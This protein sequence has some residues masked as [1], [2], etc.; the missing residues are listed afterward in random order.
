MTTDDPSATKTPNPYLLA[1][2]LTGLGVITAILLD[3]EGAR[4]LAPLVGA[5]AISCWIGGARPGLLSCA[6]GFGVVW[7]GLIDRGD[8]LGMPGTSELARWLTPL[9]VSLVVVWASWALRRVGAEATS[10]AETAVRE[11]TTTESVQRLTSELSSALTPSDVAHA[12]VERVPVLLGATGGAF[13]LL[14]GDQALQIVDPDGAPQQTLRPGLRLP[15]DTRAP[16]VQAARS[17]EVAFAATRALLEQEFPDGARLA[18]NAAGALAVPLRV[19]GVV[20]GSMG[21][22]FAEPDA[23]DDEVVTLATLAADLGGQALQRSRLYEQERDSRAALDRI[24][25]L[26][27]R[28]GSE[29]PQ[30]VARLVCVE[31]AETFGADVAQVWVI[32]DE[33]FE[34][35]WR[36]PESEVIPPG[37]RIAA[38]DFPGLAES[39]ERLEAMFIEDSLVNIKGLGLQHA[40]HF[41]IRS[42]LRIPIASGGRAE[43]ILVLQWTSVVPRPPVS[44][45]ALTRR[46][47]DL[48]GLALEH[49]ERRVAQADAARNSDETRRLL[50]LTAALSAALQPRAVAEATL[51]EAVR[52]FGATGGVVVR[53]RDD[54][55]LDVEAVLGPVADEVGDRRRLDDGT[56]ITRAARSNDLIVVDETQVAFPLVAVGRIVGSLELVFDE[57]RPF[58]APDRE[59]ALAL[60]RQSGQA[61]ERTALYETE[62]DARM[63][64]ERMA[65]DLAQLHALATALGRTGAAEEVTHIIGEQMTAGMIGAHT[66]GVYLLDGSRE[67][68]RLASVTGKLG[69]DYLAEFTDLDIERAAPITEAVR[70][71]KPVWLFGDE[72]DDEVR[73]ARWREAG[74]GSVGIIPLVVES[75]AI[76]ALFVMFDEGE[77]PTAEDRRFA[78]TVARQSAQPLERVRLLDE[79]RGS[80]RRAERAIEELR[81]LQAVTESL[82]GAP[83]TAAV[84]DVMLR[85]GRAVLGADGALVHLRT[86][87][88]EDLVLLDAL[89]APTALIAP[90]A[91]L[92]PDVGAAVNAAYTSG[93]VIELMPVG[94]GSGS[95]GLRTAFRTILCIPLTVGGDTVGVLTAGF[96]QARTFDAEDRRTASVM[97]RQC[98]QAL[99]RSRLFDEERDARDRSERLQSLTTALSRALTP[100]DVITTY[101]R[102]VGPAVGARSVAVGIVEREG[103]PP[104]R[105]Q[106][107]GDVADV[108]THWLETRPEV[109][110]P[111][112]AALRDDRPRYHDASPPN[113]T[114]GGADTRDLRARALIPLLVRRR[115][116]GVAVL[117]WDRSLALDDQDRSFLEAC[118]SLCAQALDRAR[119]YDAERTIAETLQRSVLPETLP[120]MEG[121]TVAARYLPGTE[122]V[123]VG[124]DWFDTILLPDGRLG[125]AVGDVVGKGVEAA[126]TMAQLRNGMRALALDTS[127]PGKIVTKLNKLLDGYSESS[128]ATL[129]FVAVDPTTRVATIVCA[130]HPPPVVVGSDGV[131]SLLDHG[132]GL[133]LGVDTEATYD[134][135]TTTLEAGAILVLYTDGLVERRDRSFDDGLALLCEAVS[136][137]L[138]EPEE[139]I[140][141]ILD[142]LLGDSERGDDIAV[143]TVALDR[144]PLGAFEA[145]LPADRGSLRGLREAFEGWLDR[146]G[147]AEADRRDLILATWEATANAVEH[148]GNPTEPVIDVRASL[149]GDTVRVEVSDRGTWTE[150]R[151]AP[152]RGLGMHLIQTLM[153]N[154]SVQPG[155]DGTT[156]VMERVLSRARA[157]ESEGNGS[158]NRTA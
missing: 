3:A 44:T 47:A 21:F 38:A 98:A 135:W 58:A 65:S 32:D 152:D 20:V 43:R 56:A 81:R 27:P 61:L 115:Y 124:G 95:E 6:V 70:E 24:T 145:R 126:A 85:E 129:V 150:P 46:F 86:R 72:S 137:P 57:P 1:L 101:A 134:P 153:T 155:P 79:E 120:S 125:F 121:A 17:G 109:R 106:W 87:D 54:E 99:E 141:V 40:R 127:D 31:A 103:M 30:D 12:L 74:I 146:G 89:G 11:R 97:G 34:V 75:S 18:P 41:G 143:I 73:A 16:I 139:L 110:T 113:A 19:D 62:H 133:P 148:P 63:R 154:M 5:V 36:S 138:R 2:L 100:E 104:P 130:G 112:D 28:F 67:R 53:L 144:A 114:V 93:T 66:A 77:R 111:V 51:K 122:A 147:I 156:L 132:R 14:D 117:F 88:A 52:S 80:R 149:A 71:T 29:S 49:A 9:C 48:A 50:D 60:S 35:L 8:A 151:G 118:S 78:E 10:K 102:Q 33:H 105:D 26:A 25:R 158:D 128:F 13:G 37:T 76:G 69:E 64:A 157:G 123:D 84:A 68:L 90:S 42:S 39:I 116:V 142:R 22:P 55:Q 59:F 107:Y 45:I 96:R 140:D 4:T 119:R 7:F 23:I 92:P 82:A 108:P 136:G 131:G 15:L 83:T 91:A 94:T